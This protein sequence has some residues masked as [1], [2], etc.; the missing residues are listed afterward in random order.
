MSCCVTR[1]RQCSVC[2]LTHSAPVPL[3]LPSSITLNIYSFVCSSWITLSLAFSKFTSSP[4]FHSFSQSW[5]RKEKSVR[6]CQH[7]R[8][9][10]KAHL[11]PWTPPPPD[12][13]NLSPL[14]PRWPLPFHPSSKTNRSRPPE[15]RS[16]HT[17]EMRRQKKDA[18]E[19]LCFLR[20]RGSDVAPRWSEENKFW[21]HFGWT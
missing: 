14:L 21:I 9:T 11:S 16:R 13:P 10:L 5:W 7:Q 1:R 8:G 6:V 18:D 12:V 4:S 3:F 17:F 2:L 19:N 20:T 15:S